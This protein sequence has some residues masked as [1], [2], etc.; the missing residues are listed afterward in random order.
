M[1]NQT[2]VKIMAAQIPGVQYPP[3]NEEAD[4]PLTPEEQGKETSQLQSMN[5]IASKIGRTLSPGDP[6]N[7]PPLG[8]ERV[9]LSNS[10]SNLLDLPDELLRLAGGYLGR[11]DRASLAHAFRDAPKIDS[12]DDLS[13][14]FEEFQKL[15]AEENLSPER[16]A[17]ILQNTTSMSHFRED[18]SDEQLQEIATYCPNLKK[19]SLVNCPN[20]TNLTPLSGLKQLQDLTLSLCY[21]LRDFS[22]LASLKQLL[23][24]TLAGCHGLTDLSPLSNLTKLQM[25]FLFNCSNLI[26]FSPLATMRCLEGLCLPR[27]LPDSRL[28][29]HKEV[30]QKYLHSLAE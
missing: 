1:L 13:I 21:R 27:R 26:D 29:L 4:R 28:V 14:S 24:L 30:L 17:E 22:P 11:T 10:P 8:G 5:R 16:K 23:R 20:L 15:L 12:Y 19:L 7:Q 25:L 3:R 18:L 2:K 6:L 9:S